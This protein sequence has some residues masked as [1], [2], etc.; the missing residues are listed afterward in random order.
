MRV[1]ALATVLRGAAPEVRGLLRNAAVIRQTET[2]RGLAVVASRVSAAPA[3]AAAAAAV[4]TTSSGTRDNAGLSSLLPRPPN[5]QRRRRR[6]VAVEDDSS[7]VSG[8]AACVLM[9]LLLTCLCQQT[10]TATSLNVRS[11]TC[12]ID[13]RNTCRDLS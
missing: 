12:R 6:A 2:R 3:T 11:T 8:D 9:R 7:T 5:W 1:L 4:A 13:P 10:R